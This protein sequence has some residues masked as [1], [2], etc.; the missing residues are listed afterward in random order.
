MCGEIDADHSADYIPDD[1]DDEW[2]NWF[3]ELQTLNYW[4]FLI[5]NF[6]QNWFN[7]I[8]SDFKLF[9]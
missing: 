8:I 5:L 6:K 3:Y 4:L 2:D 7:L 1:N 9:L